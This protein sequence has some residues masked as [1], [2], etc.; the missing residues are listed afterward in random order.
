M[1]VKEMLDRTKKVFNKYGGRVTLKKYKKVLAAINV[2]PEDNYM[3]QD[4]FDAVDQ[5]GDGYIS[6]NDFKECV[7][8]PLMDDDIEPEPTDP[9][10]GLSYMEKSICTLEKLAEFKNMYEYHKKGDS[11]KISEMREDIVTDHKGFMIKLTEFDTF[12]KDYEDSDKLKED[13]FYEIFN[14]YEQ[15]VL[16]TAAVY[17]AGEETQAEVDVD[18]NEQEEETFMEEVIV[19]EQH[20]SDDGD[21]DKDPEVSLQDIVDHIID[22]QSLSRM[23]PEQLAKVFSKIKSKVDLING[24][25]HKMEKKQNKYKNQ[26]DVL[27]NEKEYFQKKCKA[28]KEENEELKE[29]KYKL[30]GDVEDLMK[31]EQDFQRMVRQCEEKDAEIMQL[32]DTVDQYKREMHNLE[33]ELRDTEEK[34][35][36]GLSQDSLIDR[37]KNLE[38]ELSSYKSYVAQSLPEN[39]DFA[40]SE[41]GSS[42]RKS[43]KKTIRL[44]DND[45]KTDRNSSKNNKL[46]QL[47]EDLTEKNRGLEVSE[48]TALIKFEKEYKRKIR[49]LSVQF[50]H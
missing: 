11:A 47:I 28:L 34:M 2:V 43:E 21:D 12:F 20:D 8:R 27:K 16:E 50:V 31:F 40:S 38:M 6:Y 24:K 29:S 19:A 45:E 13:Q 42:P 14:F 32:E 35:A 23:K 7:L 26:S 9:T 25:M 18:V 39:K 30:E 44:D 33:R 48:Q 10:E 1:Q 36:G 4:Y 17:E 3:L 41:T 22:S 49:I 37:I 15:K 46:M 5:D